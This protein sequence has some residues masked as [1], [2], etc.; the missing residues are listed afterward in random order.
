MVNEIAIFLIFFTRSVSR[1]LLFSVCTRMLVA[2]SWAASD[3][4]SFRLFVSCD[5]LEIC[6][7]AALIFA[8]YFLIFLHQ[9]SIDFVQGVYLHYVASQ[10]G[11]YGF[12]FFF[13]IA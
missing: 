1:P 9:G 7:V 11:T 12:Q 4:F 5:R 10:Y 8:F 3:T 6:A 2:S 13:L